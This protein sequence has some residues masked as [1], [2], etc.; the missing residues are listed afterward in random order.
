MSEA[1]KLCSNQF[2]ALFYVH[3]HTYTRTISCR[4]I[5]SRLFK[6]KSSIISTVTSRNRRQ[7]K[8]NESVA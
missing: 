5:F 3:V 8:R 6:C 4:I 2:V 7:K 1:L